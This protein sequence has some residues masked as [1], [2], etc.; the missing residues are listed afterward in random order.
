[1]QRF[2]TGGGLVGDVVLFWTLDY[3]G[4]QWTITVTTVAEHKMITGGPY[5]YVYGEHDSQPTHTSWG[6]HHCFRPT[7]VATSRKFLFDHLDLVQPTRGFVR[8]GR[9]P[10]LGT[11]SRG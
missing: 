2:V 5:R 7:S 11:I 9:G 4:K 6:H 8:L 3:L 10:W 1:M